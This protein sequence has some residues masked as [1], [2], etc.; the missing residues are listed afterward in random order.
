[1]E[2]RAGI[3]YNDTRRPIER[4]SAAWPLFWVQNVTGSNPVIPTLLLWAVTRNPLRSIQIGHK[5]SFI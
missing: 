1:M 5:K 3:L 4:D 2:N